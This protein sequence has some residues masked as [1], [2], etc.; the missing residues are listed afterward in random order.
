M[1]IGITVARN[2]RGANRQAFQGRHRA[3]IREPVER[4]IDRCHR[5]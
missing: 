5:L 1:S 4:Q 3:L 2:D